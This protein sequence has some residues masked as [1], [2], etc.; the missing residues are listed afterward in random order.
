MNRGRS[1]LVLYWDRDCKKPIEKMAND[2][3][4]DLGE[5]ILDGEK[6][7]I[8]FFVKNEGDRAFY[9]TKLDT[10]KRPDYKV[11]FEATKILPGQV[12]PVYLE[13]DTSKAVDDLKFEFTL[14]GKFYPFGG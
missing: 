7:L 4:I 5:T 3:P 12:I 10:T 8:E 2:E 1:Q 14:D 11:Q 6:R 9:M 13:W